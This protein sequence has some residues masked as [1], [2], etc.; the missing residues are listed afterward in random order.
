MIAPDLTAR[1]AAAAADWPTLMAHPT[2]LTE[3]L[4]LLA[5]QHQLPLEA[6]DAA[7]VYLFVA[8]QHNGDAAIA[9]F[10]AKHRN[11]IRS[12]ATRLGLNQNDCNDIESVLMQR[13]FVGDGTQPGRFASYVGR[14]QLGGLVRVA[15]TRLALTMVANKDR[16][17][18]ELPAAS[19]VDERGT[20]D[21]LAKVELQALLRLALEQSAGALVERQRAILRMHYVKQASIDDIAAVYRVHRATA[22]RWLLDARAV[23]VETAREKFLLGAALQQQDLVEVASLLESQ[24][25]MTWSRLFIEPVGP[26]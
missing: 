19:P 15:A 14:G 18:V 21:K 23:L 20:A 11:L 16:N 26:G 17:A 4:T 3:G 22:A 8:W 25:S 13:L 7:E 9:A 12:V 2:A 1:V 10:T 24:L 6:V 5:L